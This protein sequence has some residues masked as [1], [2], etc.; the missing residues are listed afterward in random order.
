MPG[1]WTGWHETGHFELK[2]RSWKRI[3]K[4]LTKDAPSA[5]QPQPKIHKEPR[6]PGTQDSFLKTLG[7]RVS[8]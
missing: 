8:L 5:A 1:A 3:K 4:S 6:N 2:F 7:F